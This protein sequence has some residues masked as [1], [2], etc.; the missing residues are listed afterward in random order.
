MTMLEARDAAGAQE[1]YAAQA[2]DVTVIDIN[3]PDVSGFELSRRLKLRNPQARIIMF[4][5][6]RRSDVRRAGHRGRGPRLHQQ[7]R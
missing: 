3:L 2:P 7:E 1:V 4:S 6:E 5:I